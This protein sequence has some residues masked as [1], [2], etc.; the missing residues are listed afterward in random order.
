[1]NSFLTRWQG[2][3]AT[4]DD[5]IAQTFRINREMA[6]DSDGCYLT[7]VD[8]YFASKAVKAGCTVDIRSVENGYPTRTI[9]P[10]SSKHLLAK[11]IFTSTDASV[12]TR[13]IFPGPVF[14]KVGEQ[15][16]LT[17]KPDGNLP[18]LK[19]WIAINGRTDV[20]YNSVLT[21][22]WGDGAFFTSASNAWLPKLD[23][24]LKF[25]VYRAVYD[26][27][28]V[29]EITMT[30]DDLEFLTIAVTTGAFAP[31]EEV[32]KVPGS[33]NTGTITLTA[34]SSNVTGSGTLF[35]TNYAA[36]DTIVV[37]NSS[38]TAQADVVTIKQINSDTSMTIIGAAKIGFSTGQGAKTP[39]GIVKTFNPDNGELILSDS[40]AANTSHRF[41]S[42]DVIKGCSSGANGSI[43]TVDNKKI[44]YFQPHLYR[45]EVG[46][47]KFNSSVK[48]TSVSNINTTTTRPVIFGLNNNIKDMEAAVYS[49]SNEAN[50]TG[51]KKSLVITSSLTTTLGTSTPTFD[52]GTATL[53][54]YENIISSNNA[55]ERGDNTGYANSKYVSKIVTLA[56]GLE[57]EDLQV[58]V[59]AYK[60]ANTNI[61]VYCRVVNIADADKPSLR[62]W[63][64]M[65]E[66]DQQRSTFSTDKNGRDIR[67][68]AYTIPRSPTLDNTTK[69]AG[70]AN[71]TGGNNIV[72]IASGSTYYSEGDVIIVGDGLRSD[73]ALGR[74]NS[75]NSTSVT[76]YNNLEAGK[77]FTNAFHYKVA[78][79][80][81]RSAFK[82]PLGSD[83]YKLVYFDSLGRE[84]NNYNFFQVKVV[85]LANTT[86][87][88]PRISDIRAI[89]LTG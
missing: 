45:T 28:K 80:E 75:S 21:Q 88:V 52:T 3:A 50:T 81:K 86:N 9:L 84:Y 76:L 5:P 87:L 55:G 62:Q 54:V 23:R 7:G 72:Y 29:G 34:G 12:P 73:Y 40:T 58:Y 64:K 4:N 68:F 36:G 24:D 1:M 61:E 79:D 31:N 44:S 25:R 30:N 78:V 70:T 89:A 14:V 59:S 71:T 53:Q 47:G 11:E 22:N 26:V 42:T 16:A 41:T 38:N 39:T 49:K 74:V 46:G 20:L 83:S 17:I 6:P 18:D 48:Y 15:Y 27:N 51:I 13:V 63:T 2:G 85:L 77:D 69:Q 57:A 35:N 65:E 33:F 60:P 19:V 82:Y 66:T 67:E 10:Y 32:Y 37:R 8:L 56:S 43:T